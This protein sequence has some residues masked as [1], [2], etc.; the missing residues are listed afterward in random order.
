MAAAKT[1]KVRGGF[2]EQGLHHNLVVRLAPTH[3]C[4]TATHNRYQ[5]QPT[6]AN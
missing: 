6:N 5:P 4:H 1:A 2:F 3:L